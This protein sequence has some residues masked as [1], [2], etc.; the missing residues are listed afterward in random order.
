MLNSLLQNEHFWVN[1]SFLLFFI[2]FGKI[3]FKLFKNFLNQNIEVIKTDVEESENLFTLSKE[4]LK[5]KQKEFKELEKRILE[6]EKKSKDMG[7]ALSESFMDNL[8]IKEKAIKDSFKSYLQ[9][10]SLSNNKKLFNNL[11]DDS[12]KIT[13]DILRCK[14]TKQQ[15]KEI[16][17]SAIDEVPNFLK[18]I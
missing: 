4:Q 17:K 6:I 8:S 3:I 7:Q 13:Q 1:I 16:L 2:I 15:K 14:I 12:M 5:K 11:L 10:E 18:E 9:G